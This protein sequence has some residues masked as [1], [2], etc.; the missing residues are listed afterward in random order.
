M[1]KVIKIVILILLIGCIAVEGFFLLHKK[2]PKEEIVDPLAHEEVINEDDKKYIVDATSKYKDNDLTYKLEKDDIYYYLQIDGLKNEEVEKKINETIKNKTKA[3]SKDDLTQPDYGEGGIATYKTVVSVPYSSFAN[4]MSVI[5]GLEYSDEPILGNRVPVILDTINFD[6][7]T[8]EELK[9]TD[10]IL[11]PEV[12]RD[13]L[14]TNAEVTI[15]KNIGIICGG[16]PCNNPEPHYERVED[17]VMSVVNQ[18]NSGSYKFY[19]DQKRL[20]LFFDNSYINAPYFINF[21]TDERLKKEEYEGCSEILEETD[22]GNYYMY[23]CNDNYSKNYFEEF[24]F[25]DYLSSVIIYDKFKSEESLFT[26]NKKK[27][28]Y[29]FTDS[30][31][32]SSLIYEDGDNLYDYA[33]NY[34]MVE[35]GFDDFLLT[36][37]LVRNESKELKT[38]GKNIWRFTPSEIG[39]TGGYYYY[40]VYHYKV[41]DSEYEDVKKKIFEYRAESL[42]DFDKKWAYP[43]L[44][45][46]KTKDAYYFYVFDDNNKETNVKSMFNPNYDWES[47]IPKSWLS[48]GKYKTVKDLVDNAYVICEKDYKFNDRLVI[49]VKKIYAE[50]FFDFEVSISYMGEE[51]NLDNMENHELNGY[52][53]FNR[54]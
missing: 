33:L 40:I 4:T 29:V 31:N 17:G 42:E 21:G 35:Y 53:I 54:Y 30:E 26:E 38:D 49:Y 52:N 44:E 37:D 43:F 9:I 27:E 39:I 7:N 2:K 11:S 1:K 28:M 22:Y 15:T 13:R 41:P 24:S 45:E 5:V 32:E 51:I 47:V 25:G 36:K 14:V 48:K 20:Y 6:L 8:G 46:Y 18:F 34:N 10:V 16:G 23:V 19:Y 3:I 50:H 12:L